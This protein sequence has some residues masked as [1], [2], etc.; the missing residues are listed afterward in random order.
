MTTAGQVFGYELVVSGMSIWK[1]HWHW[2]TRRS[3]FKSVVRPLRNY[4]DPLL[5]TRFI[6]FSGCPKNHEYLTFTSL[7]MT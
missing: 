5:A 1:R 7:H 3:I 6:R 2:P 4:V